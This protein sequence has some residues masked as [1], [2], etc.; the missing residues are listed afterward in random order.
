M[1]EKSKGKV[2]APVILW[3]ALYLNKEQLESAIKAMKNPTYLYFKNND[4]L[5]VNNP[6]DAL[7]HAFPWNSTKEGH[8]YWSQVMYTLVALKNSDSVVF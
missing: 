2:I 7:W 5:E 3:L 4:M 8:A 6:A 1:K